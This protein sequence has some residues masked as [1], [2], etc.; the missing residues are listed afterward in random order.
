MIK[1]REGDI[2]WRQVDDEVVVLDL[3][4]SA[5]LQVND[6]GAFLWPLLVEGMPQGDLVDRVSRHFEI[7]YDQAAADV[8]AFVSALR[9]RE[10][11]AQA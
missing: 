10:L 7:P 11:L 3:R 9:D 8:A 1:I 6:T 5:Y 2:V 4:K